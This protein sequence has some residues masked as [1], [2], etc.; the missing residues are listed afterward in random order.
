LGEK[1]PKPPKGVPVLPED[2]ATES[3]TVRQLVEK[4]SSDPAC[5]KCHSRIDGYGFAL[6]GYDAIG[7]ARSTDLGG[8]PVDTRTTVFDGTSLQGMDGLREYLLSRKRDVVVQ[9]FCRKLLG[10]ALGRGVVL[11]DKPLIAEMQRALGEQNYRFSAAVE[12]IVTSKQ[13]CQIRG[14]DQPSEN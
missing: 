10:Y 1:L 11:S 5:A 7:R 8:R 6:E 4:H 13:F 2:E 14:K 9:Q 12:A 3:L